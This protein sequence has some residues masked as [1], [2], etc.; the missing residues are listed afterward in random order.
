LLLGLL[1]CFEAANLTG[2]SW[3]R[4]RRL[5]DEELINAAIS[6]DYPDIYSN[7]AEL[8]ADYSVFSPE[9]HYW[10]DLTGEAGNLLFNKL[11]G[12]KH[13]EI[14]LPD[15]VV[16]VASDGIA[17][18]SRKCGENAWCSPTIAP[19]HPRLGIVG[20][21]QNIPPGYEPATQFS[22]RW[23]NGSEGSVIVSGNCF[24]A[25]SRSLQPVLR[26]SAAGDDEGLTIRDQYGYRLINIPDIRRAGYGSLKVSEGEFSRL[27][28]CDRAVQAIT[29]GGTW[30][31][32][33]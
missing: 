28:A 15:A 8:R 4:L 23:V 31:Q 18:F 2:F 32:Q 14:R 5:S 10:H 26:I 21:V 7:L 9:V 12:S 1:L 16:V 22:V 17:R 13:F 3:T 25:F 6:Y 30:W 19:D 20:K 11:L 24:A 27:Q 29:P 33:R